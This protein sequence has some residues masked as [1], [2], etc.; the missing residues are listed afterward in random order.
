M[1]VGGPGHKFPRSPR[2][3]QSLA[4]PASPC[5]ESSPLPLLWRR[6]QAEGPAATETPCAVP[7][8][9]TSIKKPALAACR[10]GPPLRCPDSP[11]KAH[12]NGHSHMSG[13]ELRWVSGLPHA[14]PTVSARAPKCSSQPRVEAVWSLLRF[15][16]KLR[17]S[18]LRRSSPPPP[19]MAFQISAP[20]KPNFL[21][22]EL[23]SQTSARLCQAPGGPFK[24]DSRRDASRDMESKL[25]DRAQ[26]STCTGM[27]MNFNRSWQEHKFDNGARIE[28]CCFFSSGRIG[29][30]GQTVRGR[31][32]LLRRIQGT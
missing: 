32:G 11:A 3:R 2:P 7:N 8:W 17:S 15:W 28:S 5:Q 31:A 22:R 23:K 10:H 18:S 4:R 14:R 25:I 9:L 27:P 20:S 21:K 19:A 24:P 16:P 29:G 30:G 13:F 12:S 26:G 6:P 1:L